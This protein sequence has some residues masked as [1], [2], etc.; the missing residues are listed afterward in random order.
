MIIPNL[1]IIQEM[2]EVKTTKGDV[3]R[4]VRLVSG[5]VPAYGRD[6]KLARSLAVR[7]CDELISS[8]RNP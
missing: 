5:T 6:N 7:K 1:R 4:Q 8:G 2:N 3:L